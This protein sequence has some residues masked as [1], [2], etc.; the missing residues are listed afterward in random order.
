MISNFNI[1][2]A[3]FDKAKAIS[4]ANGYTFIPEM[5]EYTSDPEQ[6]YIKEHA[7]F[8]SNRSFGLADD[9]PDT[10]RGIYQLTVCTPKSHEGGKWAGLTT[11]SIYQA[12][13]AKG[14]ELTHGGQMLRIATSETNIL[15]SDDTHFFLAISIR[16]TV[17]N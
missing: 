9:S 5:S 3:L 10:Q 8:G 1:A 7:L 6:V 15:D 11:A 2:K 17:I 4:T 12:G 13:F 16:Y 14:T